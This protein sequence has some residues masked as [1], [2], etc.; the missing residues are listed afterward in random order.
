NEE[1]KL[2]GKDGIKVA[3]IMPWAVDAP[4]WIHAANYTGHKPRMAAMD[5]PEI[6]IEKIIEACIDPKEKMPVGP[7]AGVS[8][9]FHQVFPDMAEDASGKL[10]KTESEKAEPAS[11]TT[12]S[13]YEPM[14][15]GT[16]VEGNIQERM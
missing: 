8:N 10:A 9:F 13:I 6:V 14:K 16:T 1:L 12:G 11:H 2:S 15:E 3:T 5:D 7:K 4:W